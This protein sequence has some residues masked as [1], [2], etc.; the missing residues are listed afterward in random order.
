VFYTKKKLDR[1]QNT[2]RNIVFGIVNK[3][4][5]LAFPFIIRT[6]II[7][8]IG[9]QYAGLNNLFVSIL[10]VLNLSELGFSSAIVYSMY[11]PVA[12][13]DIKKIGTLLNY[14]KKIYLIIGLIILGIGIMIMPLIPYLIKDSYPSDVNLYILYLLFL[15]N[16]CISY[17]FGGYKSSV[18]NAYQRTD[19][20]S[21]ISSFSLGGM[22]ILQ[23]CVLICVR[24]YYV[25][26]LMMPVFTLINNF[27]VAICVNKL[28]PSI[29]PFGILDRE[30]KDDIRKHVSGIMINRLCETSRNSLDSIFIS[31]FLGLEMNAIYSNYY[32]IISSIFALLDIIGN[33][34]LAG[35]GNSIQTESVEQNYNDLKR[36]N[37]IYMW[38]GGLGASCLICLYQPFMELW[39]GKDKMLPLEIVILFAVYFYVKLMGNMSSLYF[40]GNGLW[41]EGKKKSYIETGM[42]LL[43]NFILVQIW[44]I[45]GIILATL[46][47]LIS[48]NLIYGQGFVFKYYFNNMRKTEFF[49]LEMKYLI[50]TVLLCAI[51]FY[52]CQVYVNDSFSLM[53]TVAVRFVVC[54]VLFNILYWILCRKSE[55]YTDA[56]KWILKKCDKKGRQ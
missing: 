15:V 14:F 39:M 32:C 5:M 56:R 24:D 42:N 11:K 23:I 17:F 47:P 53:E 49:L 29:K 44:G 35:I 10:Q 28:Y 3:I 48:V 20:I 36:F 4:V 16:T 25:Y 34:M 26:I 21:N 13:N 19:I 46:V 33:S 18:L 37:F 40:I 12:E 31:A 52:V 30:T 54:I 9:I 50:Y 22:Y 45:T 1:T 8:Y 2:L 38:I 7:Y 27:I 55:E 41:W 51:I 43:F 6:L